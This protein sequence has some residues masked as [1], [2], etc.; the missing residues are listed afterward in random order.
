M[1]YRCKIALFSLTVLTLFAVLT[2]GCSHNNSNDN[3]VS[4][5]KIRM[6]YENL[7]DDVET[8]Y[9]SLFT[10]A[11][12]CIW[13]PRQAIIDEHPD[14]VSLY[15]VP[16]R[17]TSLAMACYDADAKKVKYFYSTPVTVVAGET[18]D[19]ENPEIQDVDKV[20]L[21]SYNVE[22]DLRA[23]TGDT[24][25]LQAMA[26]MGTADANYYQDLTE[27]ATWSVNKESRLATTDA[28]G[29]NIASKG[30]YRCLNTAD[31]SVEVSAAFG[32]YSDYANVDITNATITSAELYS[33]VME[34]ALADISGKISSTLPLP[35]GADIVPVMFVATWSD[36]K[37]SL[38]N[39]SA[40][41]EN[42]DYVGYI[43]ANRGRLVGIGNKEDREEKVESVKIVAKYVSNSKEFSDTANVTV[44]DADLTGLALNSDSFA[45]DIG[46]EVPVA[47]MGTY[48]SQGI[49][50]L[51]PA[52]AYKWSSDD[53]AIVAVSDV[54]QPLAMSEG[55]AKLT[56]TSSIKSTYKTSC[57]VTVVPAA[58]DEGA[59][60]AETG[61]DEAAAE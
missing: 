9:F 1:N 49:K 45:C 48:G 5:G 44:V 21:L 28:A 38:L 60:E 37:T 47:V 39:T 23:H 55:I 40:S 22:H 35:T 57:E 20:S 30:V 59:D 41:W 16:V 8:V 53:E 34:V 27:Y 2:V 6:H 42:D 61:G 13:G 24:I 52:Y 11:G 17:C 33:D 3:I 26:V 31:D 46:D 15:Q 43:A 7:P 4:Y 32:S 19:I 14:Y 50:V 36:G 54:E 10:P 51:L 56:A 58:A 18:L 29:N 12:T 25:G